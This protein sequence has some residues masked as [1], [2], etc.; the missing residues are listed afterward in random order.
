M[1]L[2]SRHKLHRY[3]SLVLFLVAKWALFV[4][5][6]FTER[7]VSIL[8]QCRYCEEYLTYENCYYCYCVD[9]N[10]SFRLQSN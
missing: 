9:N 6:S 7:H 5:Y 4:V 1:N 3:P 8:I 10:N 2:N